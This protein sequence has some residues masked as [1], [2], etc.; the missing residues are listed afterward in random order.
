MSNVIKLNDEEL[1]L[2]QLNELELLVEV[3]RICRKNG[4]KYSLDGGTL[5]GAVRHKGFVPWDDDADIVFS[6]AEYE[7][8][9][10]ACKRDL[11]TDKFFF[12]DW[13]TDS[14]YRWGYGK[15]RHLGTEFIRE[16]QEHMKYK[17][18]I[19]IDLFPDD[20]VPDGWLAR[21]RNYC[22]NYCIRKALY[23]ELGM[24]AAPTAFLRC[25]Y[26]LLY[27]IPRDFLFRLAENLVKKCNM[28]NTEMMCHTMFPTPGPDSKYGIKSEFL[29]EY[30]EMEFEGMKFMVTK[31]WD[32]YLKYLY[33]D[34]MTMPPVE[35]R[36][37]P[38]Y[39]SKLE[40]SPITLE[41]IQ[42][43]YKK[44]NACY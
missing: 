39:P 36:V 17:T 31:K 11:N 18:G 9:Y 25:W 14:E 32:E 40:L 21:R 41:E 43:R 19:C 5:L 20:N 29:K 28:Q 24:V 26:K 23:S 13:R 34:Y 22:V 10:D 30:E 15:L 12:Q 35:K 8:F 1:R 38:A 16:G 44:E 42:D 27:L 37:G 2:M 7:K 3:D 33:V 6:R 4:I